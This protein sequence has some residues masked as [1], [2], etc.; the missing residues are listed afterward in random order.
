M[1]AENPHALTGAY[2]VDGLE[3]AERAAF[4]EHLAT[5]PECRDE[6]AGLRE[7]VARIA[8]AVGVTPPAGL[9]GRVL[10][11]VA[12]T[13]QWTREVPGSQ[14]ATLGSA[15]TADLVVPGSTGPADL[16]AWRR[17]PAWRRWAAV[18]AAVVLLVGGAV[19]GGLAVHQHQVDQAAASEQAHMMLIATAPDAVSHTIALGISHVVMSQTMGAAA[20]VGEDVPMPERAGMA[21][22]LWM[23][24]ADGST[25]PG[26]TFVPD[27]GQVLAFV[28][29]DL[30]SVTTLTV[31]E[32]PAGG[33]AAPTGAVVASVAL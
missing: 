28:A 23:V 19:A 14:P 30:T 3:P 2:A 8:V 12:R 5:C 27:R 4:E 16:A 1:S 6:V 31:T 29:G 10:A 20:L 22:Q 17:P 13:A 24:H 25:A 32:E 18:A 21:Y 15:G 33:S 26:P 11:E 9:R 7:T